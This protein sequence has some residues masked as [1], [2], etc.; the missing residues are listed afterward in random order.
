MFQK[1]SRRQEVD[2]SVSAQPHARDSVLEDVSLAFVAACSETNDGEDG[3]AP[4]SRLGRANPQLQS[5]ERILYF[6]DHKD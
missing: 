4:V 3:E 5:T 2:F 1:L 6:T